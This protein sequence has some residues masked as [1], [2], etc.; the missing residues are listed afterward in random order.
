MFNFCV[1][2]IRIYFCDKWQRS[3]DLNSNTSI[4]LKSSTSRGWSE[5][6]NS[7]TDL[8]LTKK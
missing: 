4:L 6:D 3:H 2:P 7:A 5:V 1:L 8:T